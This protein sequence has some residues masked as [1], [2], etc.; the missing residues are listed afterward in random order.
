MGEDHLRRLLGESDTA[1]L[2]YLARAEKAEAMLDVFA[3]RAL[4]AEQGRDRAVAETL[5]LRGDLVAVAVKAE[6]DGNITLRSMIAEM[7]WGERRPTS[8]TPVA[9]DYGHPRDDGHCPCTGPVALRDCSYERELADE[10][11]TVKQCHCCD[12]CARECYQNV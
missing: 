11:A 9:C 12:S 10:G 3:Q 1:S 2:R 6:Q 8:P 4:D 5:R 7:L